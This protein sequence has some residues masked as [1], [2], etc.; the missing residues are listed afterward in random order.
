MYKQRQKQRERWRLRRRQRQ[1]GKRLSEIKRWEE[2]YRDRKRAEEAARVKRPP[3]AVNCV[4][5]LPHVAP[6]NIYF[7]F[8]LVP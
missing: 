3:M 7:Q 4:S 5:T 2:N 6:W 1:T 8:E